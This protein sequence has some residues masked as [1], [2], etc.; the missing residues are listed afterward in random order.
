MKL[1]DLVKALAAEIET[2]RPELDAQLDELAKLSMDDPTFVDVM[3]AYSSQVQ[4]MGEA[5]GFA[6]FAGLEAVSGH[7]LDNI[8]LLATLAPTERE[9]SIQFLR[10]WPELM[11]YYLNNLD[12]P[13]VAA[14]L[15]DLLRVAPHPV[16][17]HQAMRIMHHF[18]SL[19]GDISLSEYEE[20]QQRPTLATPEDVT[21]EVPADV[22]QKLMEGFFQEAPEHSSHLLEVVRNMAAGEANPSELV[23]A[24]R[25]AHTLKGSSA[26]IGLK[27]IA[28]LGH[29]FEDILEYFEESGGQVPPNVANLLLDGAYCLEQMVAYVTGTDDYPEQAQAVLQNVLNLANQIDN[30]GVV[31]ETTA[32]QPVQAATITSTPSDTTPK[33]TA[34]ANKKTKPTQSRQA[35]LRVNLERIEELFRVSAEVTVHSGAM[36]ARIKSLRD[37]SRHLTEQN[38]RLKKR[39]FEL[40]TVVDVRALALMRATSKQER[41][42]AFDPLEMEQYNELHSTAHA[43]V[44][45]V[46]DAMVHAQHLENEIAQIS[47]MQNRQQILASDLQHLV[48][49]TRMAEVGS[50]ESRLQRNVRTTAQATN[51]QASLQLIGGET[52]IDTDVLNHLADPLLHLLRNA[53]DHGIESPEEREAAGKNPTGEITLD[54]SRQGQ[55]VVLRCSDDG[56]GLNPALVLERALERGLVTEDQKLSDADIVRLI[57][58]PGFSTRDEVSEVSGR[59]VGMDVVSEWVQAMNG[60]I[61]ISSN[62]GQG[63]TIELRFAASLT[64]IHSLIV[65][66]DDF[67]FALPSV[68]IKQGVSRG[69]GSFI[70][71]NKK[72]Q[73]KIQDDLM[74]ARYLANLVGLKLDTEKPLDAYDAVIINIMNQHYALAVDRLLDSRELLVKSQNRFLQHVTGLAGTSI[75]GDGS[76][77]V[78][79]DL[80]QLLGDGTVQHSTAKTST[81]QKKRVSSK[82]KVLIVDD[83]LSVRN[84]LQELVSDAGYLTRTARDGIDA[85]EALDAFTPTIVLT[86]LEMPNMNGVELTTHI[87]NRDDIGKVPIIMVTSRSQDKHREL[88]V[89]AGV[90]AYV[91]KPYNEHELIKEINSALAKNTV[92]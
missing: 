73:Y 28:T 82:P 51:K 18:G 16:D 84:T 8:M 40:E 74:P 9:D 55:Q 88:A 48:T 2:I 22:D 81:R 1:K 24:K 76:I 57:L 15:V 89:E 46:N 23:A 77:A 20:K 64:T 45:E 11:I 39:L 36:E 79:L 83:S 78:H 66:I 12:D 27:G 72:L 54:F 59:G 42:T 85:I 49:G 50:L 31:A 21:L 25:S 75:L 68:Q 19:P 35:A 34:T 62:Y 52:L 5:A 37:H 29:H 4:R 33:Q 80:A 86:D 41:H 47:G 7:L 71:I 3:E 10:S 17:E 30:D 14:G 53:V 44:E 87:R 92:R 67:Y 91:T 32:A 70:M 56:K 69:D 61:D 43:L 90:D 65:A 38:I 26:I 58:L 6:G 63:T 60:R 13:S